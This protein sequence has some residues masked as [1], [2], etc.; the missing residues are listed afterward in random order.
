MSWKTFHR[1]SEVLRRVT[2]EANRKCDGEL[3][4]DLPGVNERFA[5]PDDLIA[6]LQLRWYNH[7]SGAIELE[8]SRP[9]AD[10]ED[11]VVAAW[12]RAASDLPGVRM[13]L[14]A[15]LH[16]RSTQRAR[17]KEWQLLAASARRASQTEQRTRTEGRRIE[18][19]ARR[20]LAASLATQPGREGTR[21]GRGETLRQLHRLASHD[22]RRRCDRDRCSQTP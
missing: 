1:R 16:A 7:L 10:P 18:D 21:T 14:D 20:A 12:C 22:S 2:A 4:T 13:I 3:P 5:D 6:A 8:L 9:P 19:R 17:E 11:A 15:N